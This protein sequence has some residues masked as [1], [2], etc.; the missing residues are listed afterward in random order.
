MSLVGF[1]A[2]GGGEV[3]R[4]AG[5]TFFYITFD[6]RHGLE[7]GELVRLLDFDIGS[8]E[9]VE[10]SGGRARVKVV[11]SK[12]A[13]SNLTEATTFAVDSGDDGLFLETY[14]LD[15]D[16]SRLA[17]GDTVSGVDSSLELT[18]RRAAAAASGFLGGGA[19]SE[20]WEK[21]AEL[22]SEMREELDAVDWE[23]E[24][25]ALEA[26]WVRALE[27]LDRSADQSV[28]EA[29]ES[30][31]SLIRELERAGYEDEANKLARRFAELP[32][33]AAGADR[34]E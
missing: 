28:E 31:E 19:S 22:A 11:L 33:E 8:V 29:R 15:P 24:E 25:Q 23:R 17:E 16:A 2:C 3:S 13:L 34:R 12:D 9:A 21:G 18:A 5:G 1:V 26:Q 7:G 4:P 6:E 32:G 10:L 20:W 14:V 30:V 27:A